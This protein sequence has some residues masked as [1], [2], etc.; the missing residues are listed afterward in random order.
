MREREKLIAALLAALCLILGGCAFFEPAWHFETETR[1]MAYEQSYASDG[2]L[3]ALVD[4]ELPRLMLE[5][6]ALAHSD[7]P[8]EEMAAVRD[9]FNAGMEQFYAGLPELGELRAMAVDD[10]AVSEATGFAL[11]G[12]YFCRLSPESVYRTQRLLSVCARGEEYTG[13]AHVLPFAAVWNFDLGR[14]EFLVWGDLTDRPDDL[15]AKLAEEAGVAD[16][17]G[18]QVYFA[19]DGA[20]IVFSVYQ[21]APFSEGMPEFTV[22]YETLAPYWNAR[23]RELLQKE[24]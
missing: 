1:R 6:D 7:E 15:S 23:G 20:H 21:I 22:P 11:R 12:A 14:G 2:T 19:G 16:L 4:Y 24:G 18:A 8:P 10:K 13:G 5:H 17:E 3:L 9:A